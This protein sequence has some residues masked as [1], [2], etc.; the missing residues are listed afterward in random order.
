MRRQTVTKAQVFEAADQFVDMGLNPTQNAVIRRVGGSFST[1]G[2][3]LE[4]WRRERRAANENPAVAAPDQLLGAAKNFAEE[5]WSAALDLAAAKFREDQK[6]L[7]AEQAALDEDRVDMLNLVRDMEN[8][9]AV[10]ESRIFTLDQSHR[11][12]M[13]NVSV[14]KDKLAKAQERASVA[15]ARL[16]EANSRIG[17]LLENVGLAHQR[18]TDLLQSLLSLRHGRNSPS[19][20][21][22]NA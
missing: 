6:R 12:A 10:Q 17:E 20:R 16:A 9:A 21:R 18:N 19:S 2:R 7:E 1:V 4:E 8:A 11:D 5:L 22:G 13:S 3:F 15:E 14:L